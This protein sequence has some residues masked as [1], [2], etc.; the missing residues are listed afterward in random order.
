MSNEIIVYW[1]P[2]T[3]IPSSQ[4]WNFLYREPYPLF[5]DLVSMKSKD[6]RDNNIFSCPVSNDFFKNIFSVKS[7]LAESFDFPEGFLKNAETIQDF[8]YELGPINNKV[9]IQKV[10]ES[11][12][13][14]YV[15]IV[16]NMQWIFFSE[17]PLIARFTQPYYPAKSPCEGSLLSSGEFDI[18]RW[19]RK[20][21]LNYHIPIDA[22]TFSI[23]VDDPLFYIELMTDK[24]VIFKRFNF[25]DSLYQLSNEFSQSPTRYGKFW[26]LSERYE[27]AKKSKVLDVVLKEIKNNL[28]D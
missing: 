2:A 12:Y 19:F 16:Y 27:M 8:P 22:K 28:V 3:F 13:L 26:P 5:L 14:N 6:K 24:K 21:N 11:S 9:S 17:E 4:S 20:Y 18:G 7:N 1:A 25:T 10:R 15:D 23:E